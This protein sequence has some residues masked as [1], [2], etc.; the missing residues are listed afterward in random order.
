M[1]NTLLGVLVVLSVVVAVN[2]FLFFGYYLPRTTSPAAPPISS[3]APTSAPTTAPTTVSS[4][5]TG[6]P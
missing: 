6:S 4:T 1:L 2:S 3:P 5:A